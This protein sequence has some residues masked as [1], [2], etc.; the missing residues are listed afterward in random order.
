MAIMACPVRSPHLGYELRAEPREEGVELVADASGD[1]AEIVGYGLYRAGTGARAFSGGTPPAA[2]AGCFYCTFGGDLDAARNFSGCCALLGDGSRDGA[3][4][5]ADLPDDVFDGINRFN[6]PRRCALHAGDLRRNL[7]GGA[8][9][10]AG[11]R[12]HFAG[13]H[14]DAR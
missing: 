3:A 14:R 7:L 11:G 6:R 9:G 10:L 5:V 1:A 2:P 12:P 13:D 4:D 8:A